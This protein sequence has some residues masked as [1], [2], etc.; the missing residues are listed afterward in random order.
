MEDCPVINTPLRQ[1]TELFPDLH[2]TVT[3][4]KR[5]SEL[6]IAHSETQLRVGDIT[7]L[8]VAREQMRRAVGLLVIK[9]KMPTA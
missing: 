6:L 9:N 8:V 2:T 4:I 1:L 5:G 3:A 7:Y